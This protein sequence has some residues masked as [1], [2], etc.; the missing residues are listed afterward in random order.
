MTGK[1]AG[2]V[3]GGW[4]GRLWCGGPVVCV[5]GMWR[6]VTVAWRARVVCAVRVVWSDLGACSVHLVWSDYDVICLWGGVSVMKTT[7]CRVTHIRHNYSV[8]TIM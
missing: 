5:P 4:R 7:H 6:G 1:M 2:G 8:E 3:G